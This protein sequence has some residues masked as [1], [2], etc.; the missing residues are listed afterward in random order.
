MSP[1]ELRWLHMM[2]SLIFLLSFKDPSWGNS[3]RA[4]GLGVL[5]SCLSSITIFINK[6]RGCPVALEYVFN[7]SMLPKFHV[8]R[9]C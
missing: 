9:L 5:R 8:I 7:V 3:S 6:N 4:L 2:I 1:A